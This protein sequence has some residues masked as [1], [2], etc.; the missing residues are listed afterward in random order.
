MKEIGE[1]IDCTAN[2]AIIKIQR[3]SACSNCKKDCNMAESHETDELVVEVDN[4]VE[5]TVGQKVELEMEGMNLVSAALLVY[6]FPLVS[7][8]AGYFLGDWIIES[9]IGGSL[10][11]ALLAV[12]VI[13]I[14]GGKESFEP[15]IID[16]I[17]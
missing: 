14:V 5:A 7:I 13:K 17:D 3:H 10:I 11:L 9:G 12:G 16:I 8:V 15:E 1:V 2:K 4:K 6:L